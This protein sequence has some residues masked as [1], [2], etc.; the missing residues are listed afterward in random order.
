MQGMKEP[1]QN[2]AVTS[3]KYMQPFLLQY[4]LAVINMLIYLNILI[5]CL[6][7]PTLRYIAGYKKSRYLLTQC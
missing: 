1:Q 3:N 7:Y 6:L 5:E 4:L 2:V